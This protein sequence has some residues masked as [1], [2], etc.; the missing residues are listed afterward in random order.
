MKAQRKSS[1]CVIY[2]DDINGLLLNPRLHPCGRSTASQKCALQSPS[3]LRKNKPLR[4]SFLLWFYWWCVR[5]PDSLLA[6][7]GASRRS[8]LPPWT[9]HRTVLLEKEQRDRENTCDD[10]VHKHIIIHT[11]GQ[12]VGKMDYKHLRR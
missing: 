3:S 9:P 2:N 12:F 4:L 6:S 11:L 5:G 8:E 10:T 7:S 1:V